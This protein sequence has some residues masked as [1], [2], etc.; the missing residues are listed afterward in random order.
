MKKALTILATAAMAASMAMADVPSQNVVGYYEVPLSNG[1]SLIGVSWQGMD[2][3]GVS[4]QDMFSEESLYP[5]AGIWEINT[6]DT[7]AYWNND[8]QAYVGFYYVDLDGTGAKWHDE[9]FLVADK[10][11][12]PGNAFWFYRPSDS[13][14]P[15][16]FVYGAVATNAAINLGAKQGYSL[17]SK[18]FPVEDL[19]GAGITG[20][21]GTGIWDI[22]TCDTMAVWNN[23]TKAYVGFYYVDLDGSGAKWHDENFL[24]VTRNL[25]LGE[26]AWYY[27]Q[28]ETT[29]NW[30]EIKPVIMDN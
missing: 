1:Y 19:V 24:P 5:G 26:A 16:V 11:F 28:P 6:C 30:T 7:L 25:T 18:A 17:I 3:T 10:R 23:A 4:I 8:S 9:N 27:H 29:I 21:A 20:Y 15:S 14:L 13:G 22:D 2:G 12:E